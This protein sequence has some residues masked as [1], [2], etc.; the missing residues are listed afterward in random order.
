MWRYLKIQF[1]E[2]IRLKL[3][4]GSAQFFFLQL[5]IVYCESCVVRNEW[6]EMAAA[7]AAGVQFIRAYQIWAQRKL[8]KMTTNDT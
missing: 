3:G 2:F 7:A 6:S 8:V 5:H 4:M 1:R